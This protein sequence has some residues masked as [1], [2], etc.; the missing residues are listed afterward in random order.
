M[1]DIE[2]T[3]LEKGVVGLSFNTSITKKRMFRIVTV[4]VLFIVLICLAAFVKGSYQAAVFISI[5]YIVIT[6]IEKL[7]YGKGVLIHKAI[8]QKLLKRIEELE[9]KKQHS[10]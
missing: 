9:Q 1:S 2:L 5:A 4:G 7:V 3:E 6:L 10:E 8:I